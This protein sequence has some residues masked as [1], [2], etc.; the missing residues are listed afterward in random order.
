MTQR[1]VFVTGA[2]GYVGRALI[3]RLVERGIRIRALARAASVPLLPPGTS[4]VV[5][6]ALDAAS[7]ADAIAPADTLVHLVGTPHPNARKARQFLEVDL[8]SIRE[9]CAAARHARVAHLVYVSVAQPAPVMQ[10]YISARREGEA[11]VRATGIDSTIVRPWYVVGPGHRWP[12]LLCP[13]YALFERIPA[14]RDSARRL[15]LV[16]LAQMV[17]ALLFA[18]E[19]RPSGLRVVD[20]PG[21]RE[22][23]P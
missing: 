19:H 21:I 7:Y 1:C 17:A 13:L 9:A 5:G 16:S 11:L 15:G 12:L 10:A 20:V 23:A 6:D 14:T 4:A 22:C 2:T 18:I 8:A 3:A